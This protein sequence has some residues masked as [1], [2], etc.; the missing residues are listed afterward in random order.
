MRGVWWPALSSLSL[1]SF[2][3]DLLKVGQRKVLMYESWLW[4][5]QSSDEERCFSLSTPVVNSVSVPIELP[6]LHTLIIYHL[7]ASDKFEK[8]IFCCY[9]PLHITQLKIIHSISFANSIVRANPIYVI[10]DQI[11]IYKPNT[12]GKVQT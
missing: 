8:W 1:I 7:Q 3:L 5:W 12:S 11:V 6:L 10:Y 4:T 9:G 2:L